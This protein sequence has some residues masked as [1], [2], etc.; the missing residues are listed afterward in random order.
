MKEKDFQRW[1]IDVARRL[2]WQVWHVPAPM[3]WVGKERGFVGARDAAGLAD[4]VLVRE[5]L[6]FAEIKGKGGKVSD[7]QAE[8]L[9]AVERIDSP[10]IGAYSWW[11]G[12]EAEIEEILARPKA[13]PAHA[14]P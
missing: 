12:D 4:L 5:R 3:Q 11:P 14:R 2:G 1:V 6:I 7:K 8:F 10:D 9:A 13:K